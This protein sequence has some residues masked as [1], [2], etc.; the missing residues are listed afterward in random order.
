MDAPF[1]VE[2]GLAQ[3]IA[4]PLES[5]IELLGAGWPAAGD[6]E[7][8]L[9]VIEAY[10]REVERIAEAADGAQAQG[11]VWVC[12][13]V[14]GQ[15]L[16]L[17]AKP[18]S[19]SAEEQMLL[20]D[21]PI[22]LTDYVSAPED[23]ATSAALIDHLQNDGWGD[24]LSGDDAQA[25]RRMF[26]T[27]ADVAAAQAHA[28]SQH[29]PRQPAS[30]PVVA[31]AN[32]DHRI[33]ADAADLLA[34]V[35]EQVTTSVSAAPQADASIE[36]AP[37]E[38]VSLPHA[39]ADYLAQLVAIVEQAEASN[40]IGLSDACL[41]VQ[42]H[43]LQWDESATTQTGHLSVEQVELLE[44]F[45]A[46]AQ[47]YLNS[48]NDPWAAEALVFDLS[49]AGWPEPLD[50]EQAELLKAM[51]LAGEGEEVLA[52]LPHATAPAMGLQQRSPS[53]DARQADTES[54]A[55]IAGAI[56][57]DRGL[58]SVAEQMPMS[59][60]DPIA[61]AAP[62]VEAGNE[63]DA[64]SMQA[65]V[66]TI[67][68]EDDETPASVAM[69]PGDVSADDEPHTHEVSEQ[70][71]GMLATEIDGLRGSLDELLNA[72]SAGSGEAAQEALDNYR[73][74]IDRLGV[75]AE[76]VGALGLQRYL[77]V[78]VASIAT[79]TGLRPDQSQNLAKLPGLLS[80][81]LAAPRD[82][83]LTE[84][85]VDLLRSEVWP[86]PIDK[87]RADRLVSWM[88]A[89]RPV[90][91]DA[92]VP[93]RVAQANPEDVSVALPDT[94]SQELIDG[95]LQDL[96]VRTTEFSEAV[97]RIASGAGT[98]ADVDQAKRAAHTLKGAASTA[99]V[100]GIANLTHH[101]EDIL[102]AFSNHQ[103]L[104]SGALSE[105]LSNAADCLEVM[106]EAVTGAGPAP[107]DALA[108]LQSVLD[109]A[110]RIDREGI[111]DST[112]AA[113]ASNA[114]TPATAA[115]DAGKGE[116]GTTQE[117]MVRVPAA[118]I[119]E[120]LRLVGETMISTTQIRD[121]VRRIVRQSESA[122]NQNGGF[123]HLATEL[124]HLVDSRAVAAPHKDGDQGDDFDPLEFEHYSELH[125][126]SRRMI[127]SATDSRELNG[128]M[129]EDLSA[130]NE[131]LETQERLHLE[132]Q[133]VVMRTRMVPVATVVSRLQRSVRQACRVLDKRVEMQVNGT[134]T[135]VDS[136]ILNEL[137]D[138]LM[139]M[140][141]NS[142]D[143][144]IE[145]AQVRTQ[146]GK[147]S[148]GR[149]ELTFAREGNHVVVRCH[150][151]GGGLDREAIRRSAQ[152]KGL[153]K[154]DQTLSEDELDRLILRPGFST[155]A[156]ATE[157]SGRGIGMDVVYS[158]ILQMKGALSLRSNPGR[159]LL[160]EL[161][162][163]AALLSTHALLVR[164][165][166]GMLAVSSHGIEDIHY[167]MP[168]QLQT[169][170][171]QTTYRV[172]DTVCAV[173]PLGQLLGAANDE[174]PETKG[175]GFPALLVRQDS[176]AIS[177]VRVAEIV[178]SRDLVVKN[179]GQYVPKTQGVVGATILGD[180]AVAP[181]I[182]LPELMRAPTGLVHGGDSEGGEQVR[183][184]YS[185]HVAGSRMSALVVDDS[186]SARRATA[187]F[188]KDAGFEVRT[189][190]DG[191]EAASMIEKWVPDIML[192]DME[193]PR[194]NGLELAS[195]VRAR[196][197]LVN[198]PIVMITSRSTDKHRKQAQAAG[199]NVYLTKPFSDDE[200][201]R[202]VTEL[203]AS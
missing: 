141:R 173:K 160:I 69:A 112:Q 41:R 161:R 49:D 149:I 155:R 196:T 56:H 33:E 121:R 7:P 126:V 44:R 80:A 62:M 48:P 171:T 40:L 172:G 15:L 34:P 132:S 142:V 3:E 67:A 156:Q 143:H 125:T 134:E 109:W 191:L 110:N 29:A 107:D 168:E 23:A 79:G 93:T 35:H 14:E 176:G 84:G 188:M 177:V 25:L 50:A 96:Q 146:T 99:G 117:A 166:I 174:L 103:A 52:P 199:V 28:P 21:W 180:G 55:P 45:I 95:L 37:T 51:L 43:L 54:F 139:H 123:L 63:L 179:L 201:L 88:L 153:I 30:A 75:A 73:E 158:R 162:V 8:T 18:E 175:S 42:T 76:A 58:A 11:L 124:E 197:D 104:P 66:T 184:S 9:A 145:S 147:P 185:R 38:D 130:L 181:V 59:L 83:S 193:M 115:A 39:S 192:V 148:T 24:P 140:L 89:I 157:V 120:L 61:A 122:Q 64:A 5:V 101:I 47:T 159:G 108:V 26:P 27:D 150:D 186:L 167:V 118:L 105:M 113:E 131:L 100:R 182:D 90:K 135:L 74:L 129:K 20:L 152:A 138:P 151:D 154:A 4:A 85:L 133:G 65:P 200:L 2:A 170:G 1:A 81:H 82:P 71:V 70:L 116:A 98:L 136:N 127:E 6:V 97:Q 94:I 72:A 13:L 87:V 169:L 190:I 36:V 53:I 57:A 178:D 119:D 22:L 32:T 60:P 202:H 128:A 10:L 16:R 163:P 91:D 203:T 189:A 187:Q 77:K 195:H 164:S 31:A 68:S 17:R 137:V 86:A 46:V 19:L 102:I 111:P 114:A 92:S 106:S 12:G 165:P 144:G 183:A 194:M 198:V 78:V